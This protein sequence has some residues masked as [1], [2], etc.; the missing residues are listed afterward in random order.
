[1][2][3]DDALAQFSALSDIARIEILAGFG[4]EVTVIARGTYVAGTEEVA[5]PP[6]LRRANELLHRVLACIGA[7]ARGRREL[8]FEQSLASKY[9]EISREH[10]ERALGRK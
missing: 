7:I 2:T 9:W 5:D 6:Q 4:H 8:E 10:F 3:Q 1:M